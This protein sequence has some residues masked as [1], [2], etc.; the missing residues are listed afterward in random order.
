MLWGFCDAVM[1][2]G[3]GYPSGSFARTG[4]DE[5]S[6]LTAGLSFGAGITISSGSADMGWQPGGYTPVAIPSRR[7]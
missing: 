1:L 3:A 4:T 7:H 2:S 6:Y 5:C